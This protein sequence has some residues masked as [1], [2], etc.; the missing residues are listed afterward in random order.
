MTITDWVQAQNKMTINGWIQIIKESGFEK[1][2][3]II[4]ECAEYFD[5]IIINHNSNFTNTLNF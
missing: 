3:D 5:L 2:E 4:I 1:H